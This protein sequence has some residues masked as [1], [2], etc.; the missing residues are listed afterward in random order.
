VDTRLIDDVQQMKFRDV[1]RS[2]KE[3]GGWP[4]LAE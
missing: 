4:P 3:V 2:Q 1:I